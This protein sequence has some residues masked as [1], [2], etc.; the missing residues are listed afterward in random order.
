MVWTSDQVG[1]VLSGGLAVQWNE[2]GLKLS[3]AAGEMINAL[4]MLR[5]VLAIL[6]CLAIES[7]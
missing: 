3:Q 1:A 4:N 7:D 6:R 2:Q 5:G